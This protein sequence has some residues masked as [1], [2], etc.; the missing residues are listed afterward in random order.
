MRVVHVSVEGLCNN[1]AVVIP[2]QRARLVNMLRL[3]FCVHGAVM[4]SSLVSSHF[5]ECSGC[6]DTFLLGVT[7]RDLQP[8]VL[9]WCTRRRV[10]WK[11]RRTK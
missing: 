1:P 3:E 5:A 8:Y 9:E 4:F 2:V 6:E 11:K 10:N 7:F